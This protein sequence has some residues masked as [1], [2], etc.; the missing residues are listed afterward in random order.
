MSVSTN[1]E[2]SYGYMVDEDTEF[3]WNSEPWEGDIEQWWRDINGFKDMEG[4]YNDEGNYLPGV[5]DNDP[6]IDEYWDLRVKWMEENPL[7]VNLINY[8]SADSPMYILA[9]PGIGLKCLRGDPRIFS[10][11]D[12]NVSSNEFQALTNFVKKYNIK[13]VDLGWW[14]S[15]YWG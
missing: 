5:S 9:V 1:S 13:V 11:S 12:L 7:P 10:P 2:I 8:C 4:I 3:P 15:S 14:L 6:R